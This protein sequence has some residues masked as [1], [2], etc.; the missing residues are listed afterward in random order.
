MRSW[1]LPKGKFQGDIMRET[2]KGSGMTSAVP[3]KATIVIG[4]CN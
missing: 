3:G 2:P 1:S 4:T